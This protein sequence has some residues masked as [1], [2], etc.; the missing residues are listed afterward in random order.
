MTNALHV[1]PSRSDLHE[2]FERIRPHLLREARAP[3]SDG[4]YARA[5]L[6]VMP[7]LLDWLARERKAETRPDQVVDGLAN[8]L[9]NVLVQALRAT[10]ETG[11]QLSALEV[12]LR[13]VDRQ[14]RPMLGMT[15]KGIIVPDGV[16]LQ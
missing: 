1:K 13:H 6:L 2:E 12:V 4:A 5:M 3:T 10:I 16:S 14:S 11:A 15:A 9:P 7:A 8:L